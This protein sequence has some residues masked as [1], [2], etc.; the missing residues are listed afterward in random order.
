MKWL[1][2]T[3]GTVVLAIPLIALWRRYQNEIVTQDDWRTWVLYIG[4]IS[5]LSISY[6]WE[7]AGGIYLT[8]AIIVSGFIHPVILLPG[9]L[10]IVY[11]L[12]KRQKE[13]QT[14]YTR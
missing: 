6:K 11:G 3:V 8:V 10:Y 13:V 5:G 14:T 7:L 12:M 9:V 4:L 2:R 1:S